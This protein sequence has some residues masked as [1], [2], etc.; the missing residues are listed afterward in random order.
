M[1]H[2]HKAQDR[3]SLP[4][5][6]RHSWDCKGCFRARSDSPSCLGPNIEHP[7]GNEGRDYA[8]LRR[9]RD[10]WGRDRWDRK[11]ELG[12]AVNSERDQV[13]TDRVSPV[14]PQHGLSSRAWF[15]AESK[16][17][18][19]MLSSHFTS[20]PLCSLLQFSPFPLCP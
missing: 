19:H 2:G 10:S 15:A 13:C 9:M 1:V 5:P 20:E 12:Y 16:G 11:P 4:R 7:R 6:R 17:F 18:L 3:W 14:S 8:R